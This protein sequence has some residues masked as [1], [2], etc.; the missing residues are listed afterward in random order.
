MIDRTIKSA[1]PRASAYAPFGETMM[2]VRGKFGGLIV[3]PLK[4]TKPPNCGGAFVSE[5]IPR[6]PP[7]P[8]PVVRPRPTVPVP[9]R[10]IV[11][12]SGTTVGT[13]GV[14]VGFGVGPVV[15]GAVGGG[16]LMM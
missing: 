8:D 12:A 10:A 3:P 5:L 9:K 11:Y 7:A 16:L 15:G 2:F 1:G 6:M 4:G 14:A 13:S